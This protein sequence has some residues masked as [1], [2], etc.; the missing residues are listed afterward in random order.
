[1]LLK[2]LSIVIFPMMFISACVTTSPIRE[3]ESG[4]KTVSVFTG[5]VAEDGVLYRRDFE[6]AATKACPSGYEVKE[7][8]RSPS[9]LTKQDWD[10]H[11]FHWVIK[12]Q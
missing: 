12:C 6:A 4:L 1:M 3:H 8:S 7:R 11:Y 9:T 2:K 5:S 10:R